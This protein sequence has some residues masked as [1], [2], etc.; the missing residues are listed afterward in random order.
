[1]NVDWDTLLKMGG[2]LVLSLPIALNRER[3]QRAAGLRTFPLVA[4]TACGFLMIGLRVLEGV[5]PNARLMQ[6]LIGGLG[7]LGGGAILKTNGTVRGMA[8][9]ASIWTAGAIGMAAA[10]AQWEVA[11][12]LTL[13]GFLTLHVGT[14]LKRSVNHDD[15][16]DDSRPACD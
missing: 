3:S 9:A 15:G 11:I 13:I 14:S 10:Y 1:M 5:T 7:F 4:V 16:E 12:V 2:A 6:G 8:T